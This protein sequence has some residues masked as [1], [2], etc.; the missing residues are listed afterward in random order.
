MESKLTME[1]EYF[2]HM[3]ASSED[4]WNFRTS[5]YERRKYAL[6]LAALPDQS[7]E[8]AFEPGCSVGVLTE[9]LAQRC[10][11][12]VAME[13]M[14]SVA[15]RTREFLSPNPRVTVLTGSIP[16]CWPAGSFDLVVLSE[17]A[18]YLSAEPLHQTLDLLENTMRPG[19]TLI[20]VH[21]IL[22][23]NYPLSG[24]AVGERLRRS[25]WL[26][27]IGRYVEDAFELVV[28]KSC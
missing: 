24:R 19:G 18:Y 12:V 11:E 6:T 13:M 5:W 9:Q 7:Y 28:L 21:Y 10:E 17:I 4:P 3:Y 27:E 23:T 14:P 20:S 8:R 26:T 25:D 15:E 2:E 16:S 1:R 22:E